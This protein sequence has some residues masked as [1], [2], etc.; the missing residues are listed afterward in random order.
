MFKGDEERK[1]GKKKVFVEF[2]TTNIIKSTQ[3]GIVNKY[4]KINIYY[5]PH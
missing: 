1:R 4:Q 3:L 2:I 5:A